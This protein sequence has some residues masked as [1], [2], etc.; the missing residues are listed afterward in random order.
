MGFGNQI[1]IQ[2]WEGIAPVLTTHIWTHTEHPLQTKWNLWQRALTNAL[3][4]NKQRESPTKLGGW[5]EYK[6]SMAG[7]YLDPS[8]PHLYQWDGQ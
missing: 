3:H 5:F 4:L 8:I 1:Q 6:S 2:C 7:W